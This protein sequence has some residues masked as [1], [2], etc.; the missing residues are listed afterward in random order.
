MCSLKFRR[1]GWGPIPDQKNLLTFSILVP[2]ISKYSISYYS[3]SDMWEKH[4]FPYIFQAK[5]TKKK[6]DN[7][8]KKTFFKNYKNVS[9]IIP[10]QTMM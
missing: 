7:N 8:I 10:F 1:G 5:M 2:I 3:I 9:V 4:S 6:L